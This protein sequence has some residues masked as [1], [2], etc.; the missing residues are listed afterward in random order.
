MNRKWGELPLTRYPSIHFVTQETRCSGSEYLSDI[1][2][3]QQMLLEALLPER[4]TEL[5]P[6]LAVR[7]VEASF[8][9]E[10]AFDR[11]RQQVAMEFAFL[12]IPVFIL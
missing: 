1:I 10:T 4:S 12:C 9:Q 5:T 8:I 6:K 3:W 2:S 11:L 7:R